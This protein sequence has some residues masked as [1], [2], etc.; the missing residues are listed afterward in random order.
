MAISQSTL[1][2]AYGL[3]VRLQGLIMRGADQ[4]KI[5]SVREQYDAIMQKIEQQTEKGN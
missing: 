2:M 1:N 4:E 3:Q 5:D